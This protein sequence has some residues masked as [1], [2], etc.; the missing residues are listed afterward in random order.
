[1]AITAS[2]GDEG[3][4]VIW[5]ASSPDVTAVGGTA[6]E[7]AANKRGW[8]ETAW[9]GQ[10]DPADG[11]GSGC[12]LWEPKPSWQKDTGCAMRSVADVAA[13]ADP[14]TGVA[15]YNSDIVWGGWNVV[16]GTS[17]A[18]PIIAGVYALAGNAKSV[19]YGSYPYKHAGLLNDVTQ[20]QNFPDT[21]TCGYLCQA[22][23]GYD[24]PTGL[25]T[26]NGIKGF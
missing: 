21:T 16:G 2:S 7:K 18:S 4:G 5:P 20:G 23:P 8:T 10:T 3:Y 19:V 13:V 24:G 12:S 1:V 6:L 22:G 17:V 26:P 9:G 11:P 14:G 25:G 15:I